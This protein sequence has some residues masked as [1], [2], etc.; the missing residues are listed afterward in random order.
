MYR[1]GIHRCGNI[2]KLQA[3]RSAGQ[4]QLPH[5]AH[6]RDIGVVNGDV[7]IGLIVQRRG[8]R[9]F[10]FA[11]STPRRFSH[12]RAPRLPPTPPPASP[13]QR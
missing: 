3:E 8:L 5:I 13:P 4:G 10:L 6:Q 1:G 11:A 7:Q 12:H 2:R 9:V